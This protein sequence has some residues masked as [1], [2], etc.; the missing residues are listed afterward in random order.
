MNAR[1]KK[2]LEEKIYRIL[3]ESMYEEFMGEEGN[4]ND[5]E[6]KDDAGVNS[7]RLNPEDGRRNKRASEDKEQEVIQWLKDDQENNA[8]VARELWPG[9]DEDAARSEFSKKVRGKDADGKPYSFD[10]K[11]VN[12][13]YNIKNRFINKIDESKLTNMI[14]ESIKR[15]LDEGFEFSNGDVDG[16][17]QALQNAGYVIV[18]RRN[19]D[20]FRI[21]SPKDLGLT[22]E[23]EWVASYMPKAGYVKPTHGYFMP[24]PTGRKIARICSQFGVEF[25]NM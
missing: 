17:K 19:E 10:A 12:R 1:E 3:K 24:H 25:N 7:S 6:Q 5:K 22:G 20:G 16:L 23:P 21:I 14:S 15:H 13:L 2:I 9:K 11:D 4:L 8:A 18:D